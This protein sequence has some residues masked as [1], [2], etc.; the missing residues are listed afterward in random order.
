MFNLVRGPNWNRGFIDDNFLV[1]HVASNCLR[2][3]QDILEIR[4]T[5]FSRRRTY[6]NELYFGKINTLCGIGCK[7]QSAG[8][9]ILFYQGRKPWFINRNNAFDKISYLVFVLIDA[10]YRMTRI[11]ED[12][13]L[14][15]TDIASAKNC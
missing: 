11:S 15:Q 10:T 13:G 2:N 4:T 12:S 14:N 9:V 8:F 6:C 1:M 5:I 7:D 3:G